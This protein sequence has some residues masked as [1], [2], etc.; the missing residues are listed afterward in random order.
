MCLSS[1]KIIEHFQIARAE[2][3]F[4]RIDIYDV[5]DLEDVKSHEK[6]LSDLDSY[7]YKNQEFF[8]PD[9]IVYLDGVTQSSK[10]GLEP[11]H[12]ALVQPAMFA[13]PNPKKVGII[14]GGECATLREALKHKTVEKVKMIE[15]DEEMVQVS[16][17]HLPSWSDCSDLEGSADWCGNDE[18]AEIYY[19]DALAWFNHRFSDTERIDSPEF[20][21]EPFDVLIMDAL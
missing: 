3:K 6:S 7:E 9:R 14:G 8:E 17:E 2:T 15:I 16:R 11:Y 20:K 10:N 1:K 4:Q 5:L 19:G 21:E 12:E 13:H 18:R